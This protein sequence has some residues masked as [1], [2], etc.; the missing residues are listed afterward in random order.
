MRQRYRFHHEHLDFVREKRSF[1]RVLWN[2]LIYTLAIVFMTVAYYALFSL[3][4][5]TREERALQ[6]ENKLLTEQSER[7]QEKMERVTEVLGELEQRDKEIYQ[8]IFHADLSPLNNKNYTTDSYTTL[9]D[10]RVAQNTSVKIKELTARAAGIS[11]Q[12][13]AIT[14]IFYKTSKDSLLSMPMMQPVDNADLSR[15]GASVGLRM[16]PFYK[17]L[18]RHT[19]IDF[20][21][22]VGADVYATGAGRVQMAMRGQRGTGSRVEIDH[23]NG[24]VTTYSH[25][26]DLLVHQGQTVKRG[27]VIARVGNT[28]MSVSPHLHYEVMKNGDYMDPLNYF[29]LGLTPGDYEVLR[30]LSTSA[31]QSLD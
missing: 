11:K 16:H 28:G 21:S 3:F 9:N 24:Y 26:S 27:Q 19:G 12:M 29:F 20:I 31:G 2:I 1:R 17:L 14:A 30:Q 25:L 22:G 23:G 18:K 7:L 15:V 5:D 8:A 6:R 10:E 13:N 4:F